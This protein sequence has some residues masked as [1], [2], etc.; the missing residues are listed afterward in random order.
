M[1]F[2]AVFA[3]AVLF[4]QFESL[5]PIVLKYHPQRWALGGAALTALIAIVTV[6]VHV[7]AFRRVRY[8]FS[9]LGIRIEGGIKFH[10]DLISWKQINDINVSATITEQMFSCAT[11][12]VGTQKFGPLFIRFVSNYK[13]LRAYLETNLKANLDAARNFNPL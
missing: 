13:N 11:L 2:F 8:V 10:S 7:F 9:P 3:A 12:I 6:F 5:P 1:F 4:V